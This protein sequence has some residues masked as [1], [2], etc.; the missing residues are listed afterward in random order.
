MTALVDQ[1]SAASPGGAS[2]QPPPRTRRLPSV[3]P[4][5]SKTWMRRIAPVALSH[6]GAFIASVSFSAVTL[7]LQVVVPDLLNRA[8]QN[9]LVEHSAPLHPYV[10]AIIVAG[11]LAAFS[12][13]FARFWQLRA[14]YNVENDLRNLMYH[15]LVG[16]S[17]SFYDRTASGEL[18]S[19]ANSDVRMIQMFLS[20]GPQV[21]VQCATAVVAFGFMLSLSPLLAVATM[22][23]M[24]LTLMFGMRMRHRMFPVSW[25]IQ[26]RLAGVATV[27][28]ENINGVRVVKS[29]TAEQ[30]ELRKL[31][32][33]AQAVQWAYIRETDLRA[34]WTPVLQNMP[35]LGM[36][37]VLALGGYLVS[38]DRLGVGAI[39]AFSAYL[40]LLQAPFTQIGM[41]IMFAQRAAASSARILAILDEQP[42]VRDAPDAVDIESP[43]GAVSMDRVRFSY[44]GSATAVLDG[45][46]L[47]VSPG[48]TVAIVGRTGSGKS[49]IARLLLRLYD[50]DAGSVRLDDCDLRTLSMRSVRD[51][52]GLVFDEAFLFS[53][54]IADNIAFAVPDATRESIEEAA[55]R[56]E[57]DEF[58]RELPEGYDTVVGERGYTLSG[59]QRQRIALARAL[60]HNPRVLVL[61]DATSAVDVHTEQHIHAELRGLMAQR[62][63]IVISHRMSTISLADR[64]L[65]LD[66]GQIVAQGTHAELV[67]ASPLYRQLIITSDPDE[68]AGSAGSTGST[69]SASS[70]D[71][72][73]AA[74]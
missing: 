37:I 60:L 13:L 51:A 11:S 27:V 19:R 50:P 10:I 68:P 36:V 61:D 23:T 46:T 1:I 67:A 42:A 15:H 72:A 59:G 3:D 39:L 64:V 70:A 28:D 14:A 34:R 58:I 56:A 65:V 49:T 7:V 8:I 17:V 57:A 71:S 40:V 31:D 45:V 73:A 26:A 74:R 66:A 35:N 63:T 52:V 38:T 21:F 33:A 69:S 24:P 55:R 30:S 43:A 18:L 29:Y 12:G 41:V 54:S 48:E 22:A 9:S 25:L 4:D 62:T 16:M 5:A 2:G 47:D 53:A 20:I 32:D 6:R 44:P